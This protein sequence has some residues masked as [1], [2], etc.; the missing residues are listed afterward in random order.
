MKIIQGSLKGR[1]LLMPKTV[2]PVSMLVKKACFDIL[3]QEVSQKK[4]LDLFS[5]SGALGFE[6]LS[7]GA[8]SALFVDLSPDCI[9]T[10]EAN[11]KAF[12][13]ELKAKTYLCDALNAI[14]ELNRRHLSFDLIFL[15][16]PYYKE[17][18]RNTLQALQDFVIQKT[19]ILVIQR[20]FLLFWKKNTA[21]PCF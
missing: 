1:N 7:L 11:I 17:M 14:K 5:G 13:L 3:R 8:K 10:I 6:A 19:F 16:P 20:V 4:V 9:K 21:K 18:L 2:R 12:K 15:D